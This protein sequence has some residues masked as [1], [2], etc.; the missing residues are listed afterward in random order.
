MT[1]D[2]I[3]FSHTP[4]SYAGRVTVT[5]D[6]VW[7]IHDDNVLRKWSTSGEQGE[8]AVSLAAPPQEVP[9]PGHELL[10]GAYQAWCDD[11]GDIAETPIT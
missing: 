7:I 1:V 6:A 11:C 3:T 10:H 5:D 4:A 9:P 2:T 8:F